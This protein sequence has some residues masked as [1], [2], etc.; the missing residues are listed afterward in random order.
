MVR[1]L[2]L[3]SALFDDLECVNEGLANHSYHTASTDSRQR[4]LECANGMRI[5][6]RD[7]DVDGDGADD[8]STF[9][10][11]RKPSRSGICTSRKT[12]SDRGR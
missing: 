2:D 11:T 6:S 1:D 9:S 10:M 12:M 7:E 8:G 4:G 3:L 5:V